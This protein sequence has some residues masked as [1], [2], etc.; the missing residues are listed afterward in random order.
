MRLVP[1][2]LLIILTS[3]GGAILR[4]YGSPYPAN[5]K[6]CELLELKAFPSHRHA[7]VGTF[8]AYVTSMPP[9]GILDLL[10][11]DACAI[12]ADAIIVQR[13]QILNEVD[14][15]WIAGKAIRFL[16]SDSQ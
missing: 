2:I 10:R 9:G 6:D 7:I 12:G 11:S 1:L 8:D 13:K 5:E 3:C 4:R 15:Y 16:E 14:H